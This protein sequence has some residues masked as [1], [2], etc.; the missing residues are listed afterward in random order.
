MG[1]LHRQSPRLSFPTRPRV[2]LSVATDE[3]GKPS[4]WLDL[5]SAAYISDTLQLVRF[6]NYSD[7]IRWCGAVLSAERRRWG[8]RRY[9]KAVTII[10]NF[11]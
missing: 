11:Q 6:T 5:D 10:C 7:N 2:A 4:L 3:A 8:H 1:A 9:K